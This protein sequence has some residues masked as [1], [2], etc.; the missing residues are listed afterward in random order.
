MLI[1]SLGVNCDMQYT[2]SDGSLT[3]GFYVN[4][5][6][7][8]YEAV[9]ECQLYGGLLPTIMN[10]DDNQHILKLKVIFSICIQKIGRQEHYNN[11]NI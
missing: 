7:N 9:H 1:F 6:L 2:K 11:N 5:P 8:W 4:G 10:D 3:C